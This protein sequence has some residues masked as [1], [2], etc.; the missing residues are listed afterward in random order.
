MTAAAL[1]YLR[2]PLCTGA[3]SAP[4]GRTVRCGRGHTFDVARQGYVNLT[5]GRATHPGD[6]AEMVAD[7]ASFLAAGHYDFVAD[8]LARAARAVTADGLVVDAGTGTGGYLSRVLDELPA[9]TGLGLDVSKPALRRAARSH[10][11]AGAVLTDL[12]RPLPVA[13]GAAAL[14]LNVFAPR[15]G[16]EFHRILRPDGALLVVAPEPDHLREL[17]EEGAL[18]RVD[19]DKAERLAGA[20]GGHFVPERRLALRRVLRLSGAEARTLAGMTPSAR[21]VPRD[22]VP[23]GGVAVTAAV[24]LTTYRPRSR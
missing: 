18:I 24:S 13:A 1:P 12:W 4:D 14:V 22:A 10:P 8:A 16:P 11:R 15:N 20:L 9:A 6:S 23:G 17:V 2:C 7:R 5:A 21:H 19:P 3:L